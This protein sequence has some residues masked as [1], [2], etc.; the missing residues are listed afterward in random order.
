LHAL[1]L[2]DLT[3][4]SHLTVRKKKKT[5]A[6]RALPRGAEVRSARAPAP[7]HEANAAESE[8][9]QRERARLRNAGRRGAAAGRRDSTSVLSTL[10]VSPA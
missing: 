3:A 4:Y 9:E 10:N 2:I 1:P 7:M 8:A 5:P 6:G